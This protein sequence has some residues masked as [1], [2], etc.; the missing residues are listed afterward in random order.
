MI[1]S[2]QHI[3]STQVATIEDATMPDKL[4]HREMRKFVG[5]YFPTLVVFLI[6]SVLLPLLIDVT[7]Y[8]EVK[9]D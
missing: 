3:N 7:S 1:H 8:L 9:S 6:N 5:S 2:F 4:K